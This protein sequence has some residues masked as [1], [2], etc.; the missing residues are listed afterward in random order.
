M[1]GYVLKK[2][3]KRIA[4]IAPSINVPKTK[5]AYIWIELVEIY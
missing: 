5:P 3:I 2:K 4:A 1:S